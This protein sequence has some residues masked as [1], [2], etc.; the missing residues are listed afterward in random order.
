MKKSVSRGHFYETGG[1][2]VIGLGTIV[3]V[4]AIVLGGLLG[5]FFRGGMRE[6]PQKVVIQ[7]LGLCTMFIGASGAVAGLLRAEG[8]ALTSVPTRETLGMIFSLALGSLIGSLLDLDGRLERLG[9]WLKERASRGEDDQF[10][11]GFVIASLTVCI[12][13]MAIVGSIQD[14]LAHDPS[15]LIT[16]SILDFMI[17]LIFASTYGKGAIFSALPVG[18]LQGSVTLCAGLLAP[19]FSAAVVAELSFLGSILIFCVGVNL[20]FGSRFRVADM[21]PALVVGGTIAALL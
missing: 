4:L 6:G 12:G 10:V 2:S 14:G 13:A 17:V 20:A 11:Q 5:L 19:V 7:A 18:V 15:T 21:L 3:N 16:K 9:I 1:S 8:G